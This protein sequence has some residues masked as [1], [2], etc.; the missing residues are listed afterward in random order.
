MGTRSPLTFDPRRSLLLL[1][2][3]FVNCSRQP[4]PRAVESTA[5]ESGG[6]DVS[7]AIADAWLRFSPDE[8][9]L[10]RGAKAI[11]VARVQADSIARAVGL[12]K[13]VPARTLSAQEATSLVGRAVAC[14]ESEVVVLLRGVDMARTIA[15]EDPSQVDEL[16]AHESDGTAV[17]IASGWRFEDQPIRPCPVVAVLPRVPVELFVELRYVH[18]MRGSD[19]L[20]P[21]GR[22]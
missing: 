10:R 3:A 17:V 22:R 16:W 9:L 11:S 8:Q 12:L 2:A 20:V 19:P 13:D 15:G 7:E 21:P 14:T 5:A 4:E 1:A 18:P 6:A